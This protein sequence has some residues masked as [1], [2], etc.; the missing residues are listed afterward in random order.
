MVPSTV[1][2]IEIKPLRLENLS[3]SLSLKVLCPGHRM[4]PK[5]PIGVCPLI[6]MKISWRMFCRRETGIGH[7]ADA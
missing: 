7:N 5:E 6:G 4:T 3:I 2:V 1:A